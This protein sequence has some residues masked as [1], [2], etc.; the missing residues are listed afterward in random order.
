[1]AYSEAAIAGK[2][3]NGREWKAKISGLQADIDLVESA[4][5]L[6]DADKAEQGLKSIGRKFREFLNDKTRTHEAVDAIEWFENESPS[7]ELGRG[8]VEV[9]KQEFDYQLA[10]LYDF[11]DY[12]RIYVSYR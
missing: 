8:E 4:L 1:M 5:D 9:W 7:Y 2:R 11:A 12:N 6:N 10:R 3:D